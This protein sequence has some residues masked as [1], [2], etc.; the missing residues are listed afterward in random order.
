MR[1]SV[2]MKEPAAACA[3]AG[4]AVG[5]RRGGYYSQRLREFVG[6]ASRA[7]HSPDRA[8]CSLARESAFALT[9]FA[10]AETQGTLGE[11]DRF[12]CLQPPAK[13]GR[14]EA[15]RPRVQRGTPIESQRKVL[16]NSRKIRVVDCANPDR[17][18]RIPSAWSRSSHLEVSRNSRSSGSNASPASAL[19]RLLAALRPRTVMASIVFIALRLSAV[20]PAAQK[21]PQSILGLGRYWSRDSIA[22]QPRAHAPR[23]SIPMLRASATMSKRSWF[24]RCRRSHRQA[25]HGKQIGRRRDEHAQPLFGL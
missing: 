10:A 21:S 25:F 24:R 5:G 14:Q 20:P 9:N 6:V 13:N 18:P 23:S 15:L 4:R 3:Q 16:G 8:A 12:E 7:A 11:Q 2:G 1:A 22:T 19:A 17:A